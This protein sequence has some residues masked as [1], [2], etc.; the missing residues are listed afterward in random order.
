[1]SEQEK[2]IE[3]LYNATIN[4]PH[5]THQIVDLCEVDSILAQRIL[6]ETGIDVKDFTISIDSFSISHTLKKHGNPITEAS[7]GQIAVTKSDFIRIIDIIQ[8]ADTIELSVKSFNRGIIGET[9]TFTKEIGNLFFVVKEIRKVTK[10]GKK[11]RLILKTFYIR[12]LVK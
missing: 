9:L 7:R 1:M 5:N 11:N 10:I 4:D 2:L 8:N 6:L 3:E 12:K